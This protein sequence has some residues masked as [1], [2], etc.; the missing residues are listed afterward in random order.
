MAMDCEIR[1][2]QI[3]DAG[4]GAEDQ[5]VGKMTLTLEETETC[6]LFNAAERNTCYVFS[7]DKVWQRKLERAGAVITKEFP[8][9]AKEYT[10]ER[11]QVSI[12]KLAA[13]REMSPEQR[14]EAR[15]RIKKML[16]A[17][18]HGNQ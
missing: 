13:K 10:L 6:F 12:R 1:D 4:I 2:R 9:G 3:D 5:G 8:G 7:D 15:E 11:R 18:K 17:K 14:M 16:E